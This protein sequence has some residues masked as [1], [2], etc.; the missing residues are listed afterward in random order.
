ML[1]LSAARLKFATLHKVGNKGTGQPCL[2]ADSPYNFDDDL[3][4]AFLDYFLNAFKVT[5]FK[6]F[7]DPQ[8]D[9]SRNPVYSASRLLFEENDQFVEQSRVI[10][11]HLYNCS[12]WPTIKSGHLCV[13]YFDEVIFEGIVTDALGIFKLE[14]NELIMPFKDGS[15]VIKASLSKG[16]NLMKLDKGCLVFDVRKEVGFRLLTLCRQ[17]DDLRYWHDNFL[18]IQEVNHSRED[19]KA[20]LELCLGFSSDVLPNMVE[21]EEQFEFNST[22]L[23]YF[24][25]QDVYDKMSFKEEVLDQFQC[26]DQFNNYLDGQ[27]DFQSE[28]YDD[29]FEVH[30]DEVKKAKRK[31]KSIIKLDT[32]IEVK[33]DSK[34]ISETAQFIERGFD[35]SRNMYFYKVFYNKEVE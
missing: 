35:D 20:A 30:Q 17:K 9:L 3:Q 7:F 34:A 13:L 14:L 16:P 24:A 28:V 2:T 26:H 23:E 25:R 29:S 19:T 5:D 10:A 21:K 12:E 8:D 6:K 18:R 31:L 11:T 15:R 4:A 32:N 33:L 1:D 27:E 22:A